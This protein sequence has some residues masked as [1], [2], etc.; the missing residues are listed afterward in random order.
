[1]EPQI[2]ESKAGQDEEKYQV[3]ADVQPAKQSVQ[4]QVVSHSP[5]PSSTSSP[6]FSFSNNSLLALTNNQKDDFT[7]LPVDADDIFFH[8][9]MLPLHSL[10]NHRSSS[11]STNSVDSTFT[12]TLDT[13]DNNNNNN[14]NNNNKIDDFHVQE[15]CRILEGKERVK[16]RSFSHI[17]SKWR[18]HHREHDCMGKDDKNDGKIRKS[19]F[20]IVNKLVKPFAMNPF[21]HKR[22][23]KNKTIN[24]DSFDHE[25]LRQPASFNAYSGSLRVK[26]RKDLVLRG[27]RS[28]FSSAPVS[29]TT[30]P[31]NSGPL[32]VRAYYHKTDSTVEELQAAIQ[33]A[34]AH[35]KNSVNAQEEE[36]EEADDVVV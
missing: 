21:R 6:E 22:A 5:T 19:R 4:H 24:N 9:H 3:K 35:C 26:R 2:D 11:S 12:L 10:P 20:N 18:K 1:M 31:A 29:I 16:S 25:F 27:R 15:H 7:L 30:S 14:N 8:G 28:E 17:F 23:G 33:A 13:D 34:I 32:L 36:K